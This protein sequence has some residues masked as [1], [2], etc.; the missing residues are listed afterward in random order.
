MIVAELFASVYEAEI[1]SCRPSI[2]SE[3]LVRAVLLQLLYSVSSK[4]M[5]MEWIK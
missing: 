3:Q 5:L 4:R 2:A 1:K